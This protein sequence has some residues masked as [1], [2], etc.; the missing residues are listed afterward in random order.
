LVRAQYARDLFDVALRDMGMP[1]D[2]ATYVRSGGPREWIVANPAQINGVA[3]RVEALSGAF[4]ELKDLL[5]E[6]QLVDV[7]RQLEKHAADALK[8]ADDAGRLDELV[9]IP[10]VYYDRLVGDLTQSHALVRALID[11]PLDVF[12]T[13][14]L[15]IRPAY[16]VNNIV[17]QHFMLAV[18][19]S[20]P[21]FIP[22]YIR[23]VAHRNQ[24]GARQLFKRAAN[25]EA[26]GLALWDAVLEKHGQAL[27]GASAGQVETAGFGALTQRMSMSDASG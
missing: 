17:G 4:G 11:R 9:M 16:Y 22:A 23:F 10:R 12:R 13:L 25:D 27:L 6:E 3:R 14:V 2:E 19:E 24:E 8:Q 7:V 26:T 1:F 21:M 5:P 15:F 18:R 20:G